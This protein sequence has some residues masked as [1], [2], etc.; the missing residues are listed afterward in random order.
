MRMFAIALALIATPAVAQDADALADRFERA[1][2]A[3]DYRALLLTE[4]FTYTENGARLDPWDGMWRTLTAVEG[5]EDF[6]ELDYRVE[7]VSGDT[8]V[9]VVEFEENTVHGV[10]AYRLVA[11]D[12]MIASVDVLPIREEFGGDRGGTLTLL[13]PM[14]PF[15][16]DGELVGA[17]DR[18]LDANLSRPLSSERMSRHVSIYSAL[19]S[20]ATLT[21]EG[22]P[23]ARD[24]ARFDNGQRVTH[25]SDRTVV[26][27]RHPEFD[28]YALGCEAQLNSGFYSRFVYAALGPVIVDEQRGVAIQFVRLDQ[29]GSVLSFR[30][31]GA[32]QIAYP[33]PRG[34]VQGVDSGEQFDGR[35]LTNM[36]TPMSV[37][38]VYIFKFDEQ[39]A[40]QRIDA[41]YRGA[42]LGWDAIPD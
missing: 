7:L 11:R 23:F 18:S 8:A 9:R 32:V 3:G 24:C 28:P 29:P 42:P 30:G 40:I 38:G 16:L 21:I 27:P 31:P 33:G 19:F 17:A 2:V 14:L 4:D 1:L 12:G 13:Q 26:D 41:F 36:I 25:R 10:M 6:P 35:I 34:A 5:A 39:G 15:T 37:N 22:V 20:G